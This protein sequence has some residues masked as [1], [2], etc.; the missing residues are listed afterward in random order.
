ME[1]YKIYCT[2]AQTKKALE[3]GAPIKVTERIS[4]LINIEYFLNEDKKTAVIVPTTEQMI[5]FLRDKGIRFHFD[6]ETDYWCIGNA[7]MI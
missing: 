1:R 4:D 3:L 7:M 2:K 5:G 6:D